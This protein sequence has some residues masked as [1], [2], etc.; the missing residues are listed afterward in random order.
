LADLHGVEE[1]LDE[2]AEYQQVEDHL[3][4]D[5]DA[6]HLAGRTDVSEADRGEDGDREVQRVGARQ[7]MDV[8]VASVGLGHQE[9]G[10]REKKQEQRH[11]DCKRLDRPHGRVSMSDDRPYL[12]GRDAGQDEEPY[13]EGHRQRNTGQAVK[14]QQVVGR[15]ESDR[16][17][18]GSDQSDGNEPTAL[19]FGRGLDGWCSAHVVP[20]R[21]GLVR[22]V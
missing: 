17:H 6:G 1:H 2:Q 5:G 8:E 15:D 13:R 20:H 22:S 16:G 11:R 21:G 7:R 12:V 4:H 18:R 10:G 3:R 19:G 14:R 9:V